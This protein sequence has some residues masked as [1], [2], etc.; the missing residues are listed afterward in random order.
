VRTTE[1]DALADVPSLETVLGDLKDKAS[2]IPACEGIEVI[3]STANSTARGGDDTI[4]SV[5]RIG[6]RNLIEVAEEAGVRR[7]IYLSSLG[8]D[9]QSPMPLLRAKSET[10]Q[11]LRSSAMSW[12]I[13]QPNLYMDLLVPMVVGIP[14]LQGQSVT[15]I[16]EGRRRHSMVAIR[17]VAE[18]VSA[19]IDKGSERETLLIGGPE[20][21][22]LRDVVRA[23]EA[24]LGRKIEI[25][26]VP[27]GGKV[28]QL[29]DFASE[30]LTALETYDSPMEIASI[31]TRY[32]VTPTSLS[33][34][35]HAF[36]TKGSAVTSP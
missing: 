33:D 8:A 13:V 23:F 19:A 36:V 21:V 3:I 35:V 9:R 1:P 2:L 4:D 5:D 17:D 32:S 15:L 10:E 34:F 6:Y 30:V 20:P 7:F 24:E 16:G 29:P 22:S 11:R 28:P 12:R 27:F 31:A 18:Y 26:S 14:A 25:V